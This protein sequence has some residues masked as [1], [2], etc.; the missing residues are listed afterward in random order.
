MESS[1]YSISL[2]DEPSKDRVVSSITLSNCELYDKEGGSSQDLLRQS[3]ERW[4]DGAVGDISN[5]VPI[6]RRQSQPEINFHSSISSLGVSLPFISESPETEFG[7]IDDTSH[8]SDD[9]FAHDVVR[10]IKK[11]S[12]EARWGSTTADIGK[13][14]QILSTSNHTKLS[15]ARWSSTK[16]DIGKSSQNLDGFNNK[17]LSISNHT[18]AS[19]ASSTRLVAPTRRAS[20]EQNDGMATAQ[21]WAASLGFHIQASK[22]S[23]SP[24]AAPDRLSSDCEMVDDTGDTKVV[25]KRSSLVAPR[26]QPS[27]HKMAKVQS[28]KKMPPVKPAPKS[29]NL[30]PVAPRRVPTEFGSSGELP[31]IETNQK[32][33]AKPA[34]KSLILPP[35]APRRV[36]TE[37]GSSG[38]L[39]LVENK[40]AA[41]QRL[42]SFTV[43]QRQPS[44]QSVPRARIPQNSEHS[45]PDRSPMLAP[46]VPRRVPTEIDDCDEFMLG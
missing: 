24:L 27:D 35:V 17:Q 14:S 13:A 43:P 32:A 1:D 38:E 15:E 36:P 30:A 44:G 19:A 45:N 18:K 2:N 21:M 9:D 16:A 26:R 40:P 10:T 28:G 23:D 22:P 7:D 4:E 39:P 33:S 25:V 6:S 11:Q 37:F 12:S 42:P 8:S 5:A 31:L 41:V 46:V 20:V 3:D 29:P 34:A